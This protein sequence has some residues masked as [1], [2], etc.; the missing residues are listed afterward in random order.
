M[1]LY[2]NFPFHFKYIPIEMKTEQMKKK[3]SMQKVIQM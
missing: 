1:V 3:N 2:V